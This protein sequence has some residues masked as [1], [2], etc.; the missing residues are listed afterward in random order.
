MENQCII[1]SFY[2]ELSEIELTEL[3]KPLYSLQKH[4]IGKKL[5]F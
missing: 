3:R 5:G 4:G 1:S 2:V